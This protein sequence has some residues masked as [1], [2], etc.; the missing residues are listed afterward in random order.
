MGEGRRQ[1]TG[2]RRQEER[3]ILEEIV[4]K[5]VRVIFLPFLSQ[6]TSFLSFL[7]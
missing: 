1:E 2:D 7:S 4:V 6:N 3:G 5:I